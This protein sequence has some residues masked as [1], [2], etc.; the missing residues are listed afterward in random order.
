MKC[1]KL[2]PQNC[3]NKPN[4][5]IIRPFKLFKCDC[6]GEGEYCEMLNVG[7]INL[8]INSLQNESDSELLRMCEQLTQLTG[9]AIT[10]EDLSE[11]MKT[12]KIFVEEFKKSEE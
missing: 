8:N 3:E 9:K 12:R 7:L 11:I 10:K 4:G 5:D 6:I 2:N 1:Y